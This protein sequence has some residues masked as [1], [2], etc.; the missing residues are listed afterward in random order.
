MSI[1]RSLVL[2]GEDF[3]ENASSAP[4][5][6]NFPWWRQ[7]LYYV[8]A[9]SRIC[10]KDIAGLISLIGLFELPPLLTVIVGSQ[11][12]TI[13]FWIATILP[14]ITITLGNIAVVLA[15]EALDVGQPVI[16]SRILPAAIRC[17]PRYIW[18]NAITTLLFWGIFTPLQWAINKGTSYYHW[19]SYASLAILLVPMLFWHV[20]LVFA[21][22]AAIVDNHP[23]IRSVMISIGIPQRRWKMV[24]AAF[25]C[26]VLVE[27]P[28][29]GPLYLLIMRISNPMVAEGF[30]WALVM[31]MR[32][33]FIATLH[34]IYED[35]RPTINAI[36]KKA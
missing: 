18:A 34:E 30:T 11:P 2:Q 24:A 25:A 21:T 29:A 20:R 27:A 7:A 10:R 16:P 4:P 26:S 23:G 9:G 36:S 6:I 1:S 13:A 8:G 33:L 35:F 17:F 14:W 22:Y 31:A 28:I 19:S 5:H 12:G 32:P 15:I 3:R